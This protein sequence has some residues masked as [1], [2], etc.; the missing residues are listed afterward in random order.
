MDGCML[1]HALSMVSLQGT[2]PSMG[3]EAQMRGIVLVGHVPV[4]IV[5]R[6]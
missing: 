5:R 4:V 1:L 6:T 3:S 2:I